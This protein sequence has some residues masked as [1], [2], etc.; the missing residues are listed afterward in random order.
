MATNPKIGEFL[1]VPLSSDF[2]VTRMVEGGLPTDSIG[3]LKEKGLSFTEIS[4]LVISPRTLQHRKARGERLDND[5]ADR[6]VRI[7]RV[8]SLAEQIFG[9]PEKALRWLRQPDDR[10]DNRTRLSMLR[11]D[12]GGRLVES[13]LWQIDEGIYT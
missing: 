6:V 1:G 10:L 5:E 9:N 2:A 3:R 8:I 12:S 4:E 11:T 7:V 13:L